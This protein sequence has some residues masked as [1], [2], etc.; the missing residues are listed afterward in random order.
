MKIGPKIIN[1]SFQLLKSNLWEKDNLQKYSDG[2]PPLRSE[3]FNAEQMEQHGKIL[4]GM[5]VLG[6][7]IEPEHPL[8]S[9]LA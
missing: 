6:T 4:A 7:G 9:R 2:E 8:L 3:L 5:H 1:E